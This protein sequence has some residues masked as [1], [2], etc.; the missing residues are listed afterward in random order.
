M[1]REWAKGPMTFCPLSCFL[2]YPPTYNTLAKNCLI[3]RQG[4]LMTP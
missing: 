4:V 1:K 2:I 3:F